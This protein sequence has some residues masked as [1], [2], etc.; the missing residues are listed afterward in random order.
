MK[1]L[2]VGNILYENK[3]K[4]FSFKT[5]DTSKQNL[6]GETRKIHSDLDVAIGYNL[7]CYSGLGVNLLFSQT[8]RLRD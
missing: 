3:I 4:G 2:I 7:N 6:E 1:K 5:A 8:T